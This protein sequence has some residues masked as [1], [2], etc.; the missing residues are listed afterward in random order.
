MISRACAYDLNSWQGRSLI[1][2]SAKGVRK[3]LI[4]RGHDAA[5]IKEHRDLIDEKVSGCAATNMKTAEDQIEAIYEELTAAQDPGS[6]SSADEPLAGPT[7][8]LPEPLRR[9]TVKQEIKPEPHAIVAAAAV[10]AETD[11][12]MAERLQREF[13]AEGGGSRSRASR[14]AGAVPKKKKA[15][16][17]KSK[18][19]LGSDGEEVAPKK[20]KGGGGGAFNKELVLR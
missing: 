11:A 13:N 9:P 18:A 4:S 15:V 3:Q 20:R 6:P 17:R 19:T 5:Q 1:C 14:S 10:K 2:S 7:S 12:E 8:S 16:K